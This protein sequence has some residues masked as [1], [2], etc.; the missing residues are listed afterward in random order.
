MSTDETVST[1]SGLSLGLF[2][3]RSCSDHSPFV[4]TQKS[5]WD[6]RSVTARVTE[7]VGATLAAIP[8]LVARVLGSAEHEQVAED[9][10]ARDVLVDAGARAREVPR[11]VLDRRDQVDVVPLLQRPGEHL[12][13]GAGN[14]EGAHVPAQFGEDPL[15]GEGL[16]RRTVTCSPA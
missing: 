3:G 14:L 11:A 16:K 4:I 8:L 9:D 5:F 6:C 7:S 2:S 12:V 13:L 1:L 10:A 15:L